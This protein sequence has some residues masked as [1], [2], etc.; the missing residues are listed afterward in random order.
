MTLFSNHS[1]FHGIQHLKAFERSLIAIRQHSGVF[2]SIN[3]AAH[4]FAAILVGQ[5]RNLRDDFRS[6]HATILGRL[7]EH[8]KLVETNSQLNV[9][10]FRN[11][12]R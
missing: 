12:N 10:G 5:L 8:C 1:V 7:S 4:D 2:F 9:Y 11:G 3:D 6:T